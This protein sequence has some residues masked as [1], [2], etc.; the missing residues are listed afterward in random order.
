MVELNATPLADASRLTSNS[1]D[2][3]VEKLPEISGFSSR[4]EGPMELLVHL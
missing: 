1:I 3:F 2:P 4:F